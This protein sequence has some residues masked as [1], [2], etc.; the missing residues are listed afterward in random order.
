MQVR[1][2]ARSCLRVVLKLAAEEGSGEGS[3]AGELVAAIRMQC[4]VEVR[5][6]PADCDDCVGYQS[7]DQ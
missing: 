3:K 7:A 2:R 1:Q 5:G 4:M 6:R